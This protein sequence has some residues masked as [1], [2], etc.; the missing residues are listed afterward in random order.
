MSYIKYP[1]LE[2][3]YDQYQR[4]LNR[5]F[6]VVPKNPEYLIDV[7]NTI[8]TLLERGFVADVTDNLLN[9]A[10]I[11]LQPLEHMAFTITTTGIE[12]VRRC[13]ES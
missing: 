6:T 5:E 10:S 11:E 4:S 3:A 2:E 8:S 12:Y 9:N 13:R 7:L 1:I